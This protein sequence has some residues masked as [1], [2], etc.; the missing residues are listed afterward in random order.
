MKKRIFS[1]KK[2][3]IRH[4]TVLEDSILMVRETLY[5]GL[6]YVT[7]LIHKHEKPMAKNCTKA[8]FCQAQNGDLN[9]INCV[10]QLFGTYRW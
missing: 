9:L 2:A 5:R 3:E 10:G 8:R 7:T 6:T 1:R 4:E